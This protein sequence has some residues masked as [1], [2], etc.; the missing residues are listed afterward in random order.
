MTDFRNEKR[1]VRNYYEA[2]D[3][4]EIDK[5]TD[6]LVEFSAQNYTWRAFHPFNL[7]TDAKVVSEIFWQPFR[8]SIRH[9]QRRMDIFFAGKNKN[10]H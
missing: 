5:I 10:K 2:L 4:S 3:S 1:L 8:K 9:M 7:Q 6:V